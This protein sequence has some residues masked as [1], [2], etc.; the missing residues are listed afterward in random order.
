MALPASA[1]GTTPTTLEVGAAAVGAASA[2]GTPLRAQ[3]GAAA[4]GAARSAV[5]SL[6]S[7][8]RRAST[9]AA[10]PASAGA[11][12]PAVASLRAQRA[13]A[14]ALAVDPSTGAV[15]DPVTPGVARELLSSDG[16]AASAP[17]RG[18]PR[19]VARPA[20]PSVLPAPSRVMTADELQQWRAPRAVTADELRSGW[21]PSSAQSTRRQE[22]APA[23][24]A[25]ITW[26]VHPGSRSAGGTEPSTAPPWSPPLPNEAAVWAHDGSLPRD[27]PGGEIDANL[28]AAGHASEPPPP[29]YKDFSRECIAT[30]WGRCAALLY[31]AIPVALCVAALS[32]IPA[33]SCVGCEGAGLRVIVVLLVLASGIGIM[34]GG[35]VV[36]PTLRGR[37][38]P[39]LRDV[40]PTWVLV[41]WH[42]YGTLAPFVVIPLAG[43]CKCDPGTF[44]TALC[45]LFGLPLWFRIYRDNFIAAPNPPSAGAPP[46]EAA[47][48]AAL[49][50]DAVARAAALPYHTAGPRP[51]SARATS[52]QL[53]GF[54]EALCGGTPRAC[55]D[56]V[57]CSDAFNEGEA[58]ACLS[59]GGDVSLV[60]AHVF[61][62]ECLAEW[63]RRHCTCPL[64][65]A[66][67]PVVEV[68]KVIGWRAPGGVGPP[69]VALE[70]V[71][72]AAS[73]TAGP[74]SSAGY[75]FV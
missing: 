4:V 15:V 30:P 41:V 46:V 12:R 61:H 23:V 47:P 34:F 21:A 27:V 7:Q 57:I 69:L 3:L 56:C 31:F 43:A 39:S 2:T 70:A 67:L 5:A 22:P 53:L 26:A 71:G 74:A 72:R 37:D 38:L 48:G 66:A 64:C 8:L 13:A 10:R 44:A 54:S 60:R 68:A 40:W 49:Q 1:V 32:R 20:A 62:Q 6:R 33:G 51:P 9:G 17:N 73:R 65:R 25:P 29:E 35:V 14:L 28:N 11:A 16:G 36:I 50:L 55:A 52:A 42:L 59:C 75:P 18:A 58:V 24:G 45:F 63:L 19:H